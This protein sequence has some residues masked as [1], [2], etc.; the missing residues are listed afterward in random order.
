MR[1][2]TAGLAALVLMTAA[3]AQDDPP[4]LWSEK[5]LRCQIVVE[6]AEHRFQVG[7][8]KAGGPLTDV[9]KIQFRRLVFGHTFGGGVLHGT[10]A[11]TL[12][13][14][15]IDYLQCLTAANPWDNVAC[16]GAL[17]AFDVRQEPLTYHHRTGPVGAI[18][19]ELRT[20]NGGTDA[21]A[22]VAVL[23]LTAGTQACYALR[24]QKMTFYEADPAVVRVVADVDEYFTYVT[25]ARTRGAEVDVRVGD[26]RVKL[27]AD[28][29]RKYAL[30]VVDT[31]DSFPF[32]TDVFTKD[33]VREYLDRLT[34]DG[35]IALHISNKYLRFEPMFAALA[36]DLKLTARVWHDDANL[37]PGKT[38]ASWV[39]LVRDKKTLGTLDTPPA[40]ERFR[41][42]RAVAGVPAWTDAKPNVW[43]L[44]PDPMLQELRR[45]MGLPTPIGR[46]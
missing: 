15:A 18:Y 34:D 11:R 30:I 32:N 23:G 33:A 10:Q 46:W 36:D 44:W 24:G 1:F 39:V 41:P 13:K 27:K 16:A 45:L 2:T 42:L 12:D 25:D 29:D 6:Q 35:I 4:P 37:W 43:M 17:V 5:G 8:R 7:D 22:P 26:R 9:G 3:G 21:K 20:R 28:K 14:H 38:A 31:A 40:A 19:H